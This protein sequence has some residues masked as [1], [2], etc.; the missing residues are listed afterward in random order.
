MLLV[1]SDPRL[2]PQDLTASALFSR[3]LMHFCAAEI[4]THSH[5]SASSQLTPDSPP[6]PTVTTTAYRAPTGL[7][8]TPFSHP[9]TSDQLL[10]DLEESLE[11]LED[12]LDVLFILEKAFEDALKAHVVPKYPPSPPFPSDPTGSKVDTAQRQSPR[13]PEPLQADPANSHPPLTIASSDGTPPVQEFEPL[14]AGS[15]T[16]LVAILDHHDPGHPNLP[17]GSNPM[18]SCDAVLRIAHLGDS[19]GMLIRGDEIVW[20]SEEM[21][22]KVPFPR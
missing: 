9:E 5:S 22:L 6:I 8:H 12:G 2:A 14:L 13:N 1:S 11:D 15:S 19:M 21:W 20:R 4:E 10:E 3:R 18:M 17:D 16:A 7:H